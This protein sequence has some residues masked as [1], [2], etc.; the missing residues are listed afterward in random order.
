MGLSGDPTLPVLNRNSL[1]RKSDKSFKE[2]GQHVEWLTIAWQ[3][4]GTVD[5]INI[6]TI[7]QEVGQGEGEG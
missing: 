7:L 3:I 2:A 5:T 1:G 4:S 6:I